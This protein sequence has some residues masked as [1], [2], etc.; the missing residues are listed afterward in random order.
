MRKVALWAGTVFVIIILGS[1]GW[2]VA[3]PARLSAG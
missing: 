1:V 2:L 3:T